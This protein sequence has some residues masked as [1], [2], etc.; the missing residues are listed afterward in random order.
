MGKKQNKKEKIT[1]VDDGSSV[2]D[3]S[4]LDGKGKSKKSPRTEAPGRSR[5]PLKEQWQTFR[6]AQR[7]LFLPM[8]AVLGIIALAFLLVYL[9]L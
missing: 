3:M 2:A 4:V 1:Y 6:D 9:I 8:L 5:A 7:M